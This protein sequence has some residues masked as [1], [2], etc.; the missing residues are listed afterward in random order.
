M[1]AGGLLVEM[2]GPCRWRVDGGFSRSDHPP[3]VASCAQVHFI[4]CLA[5]VVYLHVSPTYE[6]LAMAMVNLP[7]SCRKHTERDAGENVSQL[8]STPVKHS[9]SQ[10][11]LSWVDT[12]TRLTLNN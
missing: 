10:R 6:Q 8:F 3:S 7:L 4:D 12:A 11:P 2:T 5:A 1:R 9:P